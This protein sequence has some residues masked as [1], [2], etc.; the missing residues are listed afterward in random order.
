MAARSSN[1]LT[2]LGAKLAL[3]GIMARVALGI[4]G[5]VILAMTVAA[6]AVGREGARAP[7][8]L[9]PQ[10]TSSALAWTAGLLFAFAASSQ[11]LRQDREFGIRQLM[12]LRGK[13]ARGYLW[14]RALGLGLL[15]LAIVGGGSLLTGIAAALAART[16]ALALAAFQGTVA[17][18]VYA[19]AFAAVM[20]PLSLA[21]LGSRPRA[22]GYLWFLVLL[23]LPDWLA[24]FTENL[25]PDGWSDVLSIPSALATLRGA[26]MP[27]HVDG[28][29]FVRAAFVVILASALAMAWMRKAAAR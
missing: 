6:V 24:G 8:D 11:A 2:M 28:L 9:M 27:E 23:V 7:L 4:A 3:E 14:G 18:L 20:A 26:L 17:S 21:A 29:R 10:I 15:L 16:P 5:L 25:V 1:F 19:V 22:G 13:S 12:L